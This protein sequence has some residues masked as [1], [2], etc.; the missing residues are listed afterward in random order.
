VERINFD[1]Y[2][3]VQLTRSDSWAEYSTDATI[4]SNEILRLGRDGNYRLSTTLIGQP[5]ITF[6]NPNLDGDKVRGFDW[7]LDIPASTDNSMVY[8]L[9]AEKESLWAWLQQVYPTGEYRQFGPPQGDGATIVEEAIISNDAVLGARGIDGT[10]TPANGAP[11]NQRENALDLDWSAQQP[12]SLPMDAVWSGVLEAPEYKDYTTTLELPGSARVFLD[13]ER[14]AEGS[15]RLS[16]ARTLY[17]GEHD[18][19]IEA[20]IDRP[21]AIRLLWKDA[22]VPATAYFSYP[23][24]G[25]GLIGSFYGNERWQGAP[26]LVQLDPFVAFSYHSELDFIGRPFTATWKGF[27]DVPNTGDYAFQLEA[28]QEGTLLIDGQTVAA[29]PG[30]TQSIQLIGGRHP[31]EVRLLNKS[32]GARIFLTWQPPSVDEWQVISPDRFWPR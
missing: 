11:V 7:V 15:D 25:H 22:P 20:H 8:L 12:V 30:L 5:T 26:A 19:R 10:Y 14:V 16:F 24:A 23:L 29:E 6:Q 4:A 2:F 13:G 28:R 3:N 18:L 1:K 21:G 27:L 17:K 9:D 31:I 32:G